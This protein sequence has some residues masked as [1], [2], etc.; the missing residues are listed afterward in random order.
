MVGYEFY[1]FYLCGD[2]IDPIE[3]HIAFDKFLY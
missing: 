1:F 2:S 3:L